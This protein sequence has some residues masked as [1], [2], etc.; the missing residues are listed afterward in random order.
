MHV[1]ARQG[2]FLRGL[3]FN[4]KQGWPRSW[5]KP[6]PQRLIRFLYLTQASLR[7]IIFLLLSANR[8]LVENSI[9]SAF[10]K[11]GA[12]ECTIFLPFFKSVSSSIEKQMLFSTI[13]VARLIYVFNS[14]KS[15]KTGFLTTSLI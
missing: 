14:R 7:S 6:L 5:L 13:K 1:H 15:L 12:S 4:Q 3:N 9:F 2:N 11:F 10:T 8:N